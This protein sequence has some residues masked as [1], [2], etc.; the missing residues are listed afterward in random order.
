M[1]ETTES[2]VCLHLPPLGAG[3][4]NTTVLPTHDLYQDGH[5]SSIHHGIICGVQLFA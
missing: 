2:L 5:Q 3:G 4:V 1:M